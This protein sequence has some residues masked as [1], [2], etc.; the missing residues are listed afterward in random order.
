MH[1]SGGRKTVV[2]REITP[3][4]TTIEPFRILIGRFQ[5]ILHLVVRK[6]CMLGYFKCSKL[7]NLVNSISMGEQIIHFL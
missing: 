3:Y 1:Q 4:V 5:N 7:P 2:V 6:T